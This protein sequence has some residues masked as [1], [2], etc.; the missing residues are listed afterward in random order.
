MNIIHLQSRL[1]K[2]SD[3]NKSLPT[4]Q[5]INARLIGLGAD[6]ETEWL[7]ITAQSRTRAN[8][9]QRAADNMG[10]E[11]ETIIHRYRAMQL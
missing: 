6:P 11:L 5:E 1:E 7:W 8:F 4:M 3:K 10:I 9:E 2:V